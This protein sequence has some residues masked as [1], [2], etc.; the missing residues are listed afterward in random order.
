MTAGMAGTLQILL[1]LA[2][3][4]ARVLL[5]SGLAYLVGW[6]VAQGYG[7]HL[8]S[9]VGTEKDHWSDATPSRQSRLNTGQRGVR[10]N[11]LGVGPE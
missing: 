1:G 6:L 3:I 4:A 8:W 10:G 5:F 7:M 9:V 2:G 11:R